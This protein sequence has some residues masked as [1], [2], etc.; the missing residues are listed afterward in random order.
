MAL[1]QRLGFQIVEVETE[2]AQ[3]LAM[4]EVQVIVTLRIAG[5]TQ[6]MLERLLDIGIF[7]LAAR[8]RFLPIA[9]MGWM[10]NSPDLLSH[11]LSS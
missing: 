7:A 9:G 6:E 4:K 5:T 10:G 11:V 2:A 3:V 1:K 8:Q